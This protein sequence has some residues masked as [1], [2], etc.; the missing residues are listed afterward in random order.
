MKRWRRGTSRFGAAKEVVRQIYEH[1]NVEL[2]GEWVDEIGRDFISSWMPIEVRRLGRTIVAWKRQIITWHQA[3]VTNGPTE[4]IN[5]LVK[6]V[7][8]SPSDSAAS[9]TTASAPCSTPDNPR[10]HRLA[11]IT[12]RCTPKNR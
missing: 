12:S 4:A 11:T 3:H 5:N 7:K 6:R 1:T 9:T 2:A 10:W 8:R